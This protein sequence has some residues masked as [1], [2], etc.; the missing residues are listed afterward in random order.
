MYSLFESID[1]YVFHLHFT[2]IYF[3][4]LI[5]FETALRLEDII[6]YKHTVL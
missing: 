5:V 3:F 1:F 2:Q 6:L 4:V